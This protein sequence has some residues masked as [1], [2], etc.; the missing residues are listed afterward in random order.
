MVWECAMCGPASHLEEARA[1][2][3]I[4]ILNERVRQ[5]V[6][7]ARKR[8]HALGEFVG[9]RI[10]VERVRRLRAPGAGKLA[11]AVVDDGERQV[12]GRQRVGTP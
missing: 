5:A 11:V 10:I 9:E 1:V 2:V 3:H 12:V 8:V 6:R 4:G 7:A